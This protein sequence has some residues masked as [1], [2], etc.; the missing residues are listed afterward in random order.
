MNLEEQ[1]NQ[2]EVDTLNIHAKLHILSHALKSTE[3]RNLEIIVLS[4]YV[5]EII[6]DLI[7]ARRF[8]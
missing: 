2:L 3:E 4:K 6:E 7:S 8:F 1:L 5:D